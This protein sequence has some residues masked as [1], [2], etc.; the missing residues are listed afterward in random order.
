MKQLLKTIAQRFGYD[1]LHLPTDPN[2]RQWLE[3][4]NANQINLIFDVG[5]NIGQFGR[6]VRSLGYTE[7]IV[8]FEPIKETYQKLCTNVA[9]DSHWKTVHSAIGNY[10][11]PGQINVSAN[12]YSSSVLNMLPV[13]IESAPDA[14]YA[15][16]E[17]I[18]VQKIDSIIDQ[19][20]RP[21]K[22]LYVKIDT[23]GFERQVFEGSLQSLHKIKGF[24]MELSL[25]PMYEG[26]TLMEEM[27]QLMRMEGYKLKLLDSGHRNYKTGELLQLEGYFFR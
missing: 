19:Y 3:L 8:S 12:S 7:E 16:Q 15:R 17:T 18:R 9:T 27:V 20:Y 6:R 5:A 21:S 1:I 10:D 26:E 4:I 11:G 13:H 24:Q 14:V 25:Q 2:A 22:N 23:Q